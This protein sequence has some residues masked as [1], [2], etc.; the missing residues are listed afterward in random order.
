MFGETFDQPNA[1]ADPSEPLMNDHALGL[2]AH[3]SEQSLSDLAA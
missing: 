1:A 2:A 3:F